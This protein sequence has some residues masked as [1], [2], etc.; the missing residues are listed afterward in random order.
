MT[1]SLMVCGH[2]HFEA[3]SYQNWGEMSPQQMSLFALLFILA[4]LPFKPEV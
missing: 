1:V 4:F 3:K 2:G